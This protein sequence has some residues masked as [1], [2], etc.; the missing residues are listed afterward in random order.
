MRGARDTV[1]LHVLENRAEG[2][3]AQQQ[4]IEELRKGGGGG[5]AGLGSHLDR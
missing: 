4:L 5:I 3:G 1:P 2:A